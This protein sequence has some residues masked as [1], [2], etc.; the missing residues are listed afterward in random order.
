[1]LHRYIILFSIT[2]LLSACYGSKKPKKPENLISKKEMVNILI[3]I[4]IMTSVYGGNQDI[5]NAHG[6]N[7]EDYIYKKYNI[8]SLQFALSNEYYSFYMNEYEDIYTKVNDS[9]T[10]LQEVYK[11]QN[12]R[13]IAEKRI[14]D[15]ISRTTSTDGK[16]LFE[17]EPENEFDGLIEP[18]FEREFQLQ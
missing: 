2:L 15:S 1:M 12:E 11:K 8:D 6:I 4:R 17:K 13:E 3:D 7:Q 9:L 5:L 10:M 18:S 16:H 14:Q